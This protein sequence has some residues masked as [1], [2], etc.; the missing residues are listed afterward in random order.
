VYP[1]DG[2]KLLG[3]PLLIGFEGTD[4][5]DARESI[6]LLQPG[7]LVLL[8]RNIRSAA[9]LA[10]LTSGVQEQAHATGLPPLFISLD[11]EGGAV[12]RLSSAAGFTDLPS[13]TA[14]G[15]IGPQ[16]ATAVADIAAREMAS[17]G[18]N[19]NLAPV[20][21][22]ATDPR[23][24]VIGTRS[25]GDNAQLVAELA[26]AVIARHRDHGVLTVA[27]HFPGHGPTDVD[28]HLELPVLRASLEEMEELHLVPFRRAVLAGVDAI[29]TAHVVS[30]L[31]P[32]RP[33]TLSRKT[34]SGLLREKWNFDGLIITD[35]L[36]M[37]ALQRAG[38]D[39]AEAA[40]ESLRAGADMLIFEGD[41]EATSMALEA[42]GA[43]ASDELL[44]DRWHRIQR[45][46][47]RL[48]ASGDGAVGAPADRAAAVRWA[49][50]GID[51]LDSG[52]VLPLRARPRVLPS[53]AGRQFAAAVDL[54]LA[55]GVGEGEAGS[56]L[57]MVVADEEP[58]STTMSELGA[59]A[60]AGGA[61]VVLSLGAA[62]SIDYLP[63]GVGVLLTYDLPVGMWG[64]LA[65]WLCGERP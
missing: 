60:A 7:G 3:Q 37:R 53:E 21:D 9:Q 33:A 46:K 62:R 1:T 12:L 65:A 32:E 39:R 18:L 48:R 17:V 16:A 19:M 55:D 20:V 27:K 13:A 2:R 15:R 54:P 44:I 30:A 64:D 40:I 51:V 5:A 26:D 6:E 23:N 52:N 35:S 42:A 8:P 29:M 22:L 34:L 59:R 50:A 56:P 10:E 61:V 63:P 58:D 25:Y 28:S 36:E 38:F 14:V 41:A 24:T 4:A 47:A 43:A 11:Q 45:A 49:L 31:D 57:V